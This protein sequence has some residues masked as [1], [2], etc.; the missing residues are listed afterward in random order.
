MHVLFK[1]VI[2]FAFV[3]AL[4]AL[5]I[6]CGQSHRQAPIVV[7]EQKLSR[8]TVVGIAD[9]IER[10]STFVWLSPELPTPTEQ[11]SALLIRYNWLIGEAADQGVSVSDE[12]ASGRL[13]A[14]EAAYTGG[15]DVYQ[16]MLRQTGETQAQAQLAVS[17]EISAERLRQKILRSVPRPGRA[18][19]LS[20]YRSHLSR[21]RVPGERFFNLAER[22]DGPAELASARRAMAEGHKIRGAPYEAE[23]N[24]SLSQDLVA[25]SVGD[26]KVVVKAIFSTPPGVVAGPFKFF[27]HKAIFKVDR[28]VAGYLKP[29]SQVSG[30]IAARLR[31]E[32]VARARAKFADGWRSKWTARTE[33]AS[34]YVVPGCREYRG[35][36]VPEEDPLSPE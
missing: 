13:H 8:T 3:A 19:I 2:G 29:L 34:G 20:Y 24:E 26:K 9:A 33:C 17:A 22:I 25:K 35:R 28:V 6:G 32:A 7:G 4:A 1:N 23:F 18:A 21:Y 27:G 12:T 36:Q 31:T 30:Q 14:R 15:Q 16:A 11:A 10:G 5:S